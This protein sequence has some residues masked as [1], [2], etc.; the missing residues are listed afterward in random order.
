MRTK[1]HRQTLFFSV[2]LPNS[3]RDSVLSQLM[4]YGT[5]ISLAAVKLCTIDL[6]LLKAHL[7][8]MEELLHSATTPESN[9]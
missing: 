2:N 8:T 3:P 4:L 7:S 1:S 6:W 9:S 5:A